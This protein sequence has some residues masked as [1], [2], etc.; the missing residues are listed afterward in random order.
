MIEKELIHQ[1]AEDI[2]IFEADLTDEFER[3]RK[4]ERKRIP[5]WPWF[6]AAA[7]SIVLLLTFHYINKVEPE[8]E[9][10]VVAEVV[11]VAEPETPQTTA[12]TE[13]AEH[14]VVAQAEETNH[15]SIKKKKQDSEK[16]LAKHNK[17]DKPEK[18]KEAQ[19]EPVLAESKPQQSNEARL[20]ASTREQEE[21]LIPPE[22]QALVDIF[23]AEEALQVAYELR[24]QQE[25]IRAYAASLTGEE[26]AK[27][28]I[29]L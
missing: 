20:S 26:L 14:P 2:D 24:A 11:E 16:V 5:L 1:A 15:K 29:A 7:A 17:P 8:T 10:P 6:G 12:P 21:N 4:S 18:A 23:L 27:P 28:I 3:L 13:V 9:Q 25:A 22:K 19:V